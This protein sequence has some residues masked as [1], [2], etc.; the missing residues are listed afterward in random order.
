[1]SMTEVTQQDMALTGKN[2]EPHGFMSSFKGFHH[3]V[4][5]VSQYV[6]R[7]LSG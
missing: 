2:I 6:Q 7:L 4:A 1:M 3:M 5:I